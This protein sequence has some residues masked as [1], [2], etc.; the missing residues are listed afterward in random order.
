[1]YILSEPPIA[2]MSV[3]AVTVPAAIGL[4]TLFAAAPSCLVVVGAATLVVLYNY[5][6]FAEITGISIVGFGLAAAACSGVVL[7]SSGLSLLSSSP[8]VLGVEATAS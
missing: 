3:A 5:A 6:F 2:A 7:G 4:V 1:M 8:V